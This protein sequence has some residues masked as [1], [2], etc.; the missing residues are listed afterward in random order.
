MPARPPN[1]LL[2]YDIP[3]DTKRSKIADA[4]LDYGLDRVQCSAFRGCLPPG[5]QTELMLKIKKILGK[6]AGC[7][8][9]YPI[10]Q[11]DWAKRREIDQKEG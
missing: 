7:I 11:D 1:L 9:L 8:H 4:C 3:N 2:I 6:K 10:S 5:L